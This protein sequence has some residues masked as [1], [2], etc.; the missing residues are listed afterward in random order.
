MEISD[1][2]RRVT[3]GNCRV[4]DAAPSLNS[5]GSTS[6][7]LAIHD[8]RWKW[9][10]GQVTGEY[11]VWKAGKIVPGTERTPRQLAKLCFQACKETRFNLASMP[12]NVFPYVN[13][14]MT[15]PADALD[16]LLEDLNSH[17]CLNNRDIAVIYA[18]GVGQDLPRLPVNSGG[19]SVDLGSPADKIG[20]VSTPFVWQLDIELEPVGLDADG[21][22]KPIDDLSYKPTA[23]WGKYN[24]EKFL[25]IPDRK[26]RKLA[27]NTVWRWYRIKPDPS[28]K[29]AS[30]NKAI[31]DFRQVLPLLDYQLLEDEVD[32]TSGETA[33]K[34]PE[35]FGQFFDKKGSGANNFPTTHTL[36]RDLTTDDG[37]RQLYDGSFQIDNELGIVKF[38]DPVYYLSL[39]RHA[40]ANVYI[41]P[42][43]RLRIAVNYRDQTTRGAFRLFK[44]ADTPGPLLGTATE[45]IVREDIHPTWYSDPTKVEL[46]PITNTAQTLAQMNYYL[47]EEL[48]KFRL[49]SPANGSYPLL[50]PMAPD[51]RIAQVTWAIDG[52]GAFSTQVH[53]T[54]EGLNKVRTLKE[55]RQQA[56]AVRAAEAERRRRAK[57]KQQDDRP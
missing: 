1:G 51:G 44:T 12:N 16:D 3:F 18:D 15:R 14:D 29:L 19:V 38:A 50:I 57:K 55:R 26:N 17:V 4:T 8:R 41:P 10:R 32:E 36:T 7:R 27:S 20:I 52:S 31:T 39:K 45:W 43:L 48:K 34:R 13:W 40:A 22:V 28:K 30:V 35:V 46:T 21:K 42:V 47:R 24:P 54:I 49:P 2:P 56:R 25:I 53:R 9:Q 33:R 37:K 5:D 11:N 23:G 6:H